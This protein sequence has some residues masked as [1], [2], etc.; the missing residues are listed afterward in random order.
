MWMPEWMYER[1]PLFYVVA[2]GACLWFL[3]A[4]FPGTLSA[5]FLFGAALLTQN[6]RRIA[7]RAPLPRARRRVSSGQPS[8]W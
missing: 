5:V 3:G 6:R 2:G 1:L 7:R 8:T 4:S